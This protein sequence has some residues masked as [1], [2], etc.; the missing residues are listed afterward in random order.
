MVHNRISP[1]LNFVSDEMDYWVKTFYT[2]TTDTIK[3]IWD[4]SKPYVQELLNDLSTNEFEED[5]LS[6]RKFLNESFYSD[7]FYCQS[8]LTYAYQILDDLAIKDHLQTIP[9]IFKEMWEV[10]GG[11]AQ[12]S[13]T[14]IIATVKQILTFSNCLHPF[15]LVDKR[16]LQRIH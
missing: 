4:E 13:I 12:P 16:I 2:E 15:V 8:L 9:K 10:L 7:D 6:F 11:R 14:S 1:E 5:M 3:G